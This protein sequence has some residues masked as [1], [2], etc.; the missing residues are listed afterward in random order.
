MRRRT[1]G[2]LAVIIIVAITVPSVLFVLNGMLNP[3]P[4]EPLNL[5][6]APAIIRE[7]KSDLKEALSD[8]TFS[9]DDMMN[10]SIFSDYV[11]A[12]HPE[13]QEIA[14]GWEITAVLEV[15]DTGYLWFI[16][17]NDT[18]DLEARLDPPEN[19][20]VTMS[21]SMDT[22]TEIFSCRTTAVSEFQR[23]MVGFDGPLQ[24]ALRIDRLNTIYSTTIMDT[25][26]YHSSD[27]LEIKLTQA[28][29]EASTPGLTLFPCVEVIITDESSP[30][31]S[32]G[33][34]KVMILDDEGQLVAQLDDSLHS[35]HKFFNSTAV[36]MGG[37]DGFME[38][39]DFKSDTRVTL[40]VPAGHHELDY[41]PITDT[42]MVLET[43]TAGEM[44]DGLEV[45]YDT[46]SEYSWEGDLLW[47]W[48][49][50]VHYPFNSTIH[51]TLG[52]N[53]TFRGYADW[54]HAN[55]FVWDKVE[56]TIWLNVRNQDTL[57]KIDKDTGEIVWKAG[58]HGNFTVLDI[59]GT[60][61]DTITNYPHS[62]EWIGGNRYIL[63][64]NGLFNPD[65]PSSMSQDGTGISGFVEFEID[66]ENQILREVW[67]WHALNE[68]YYFSESGGDADR[69]PDGNTLGIY[70]NMALVQAR[71]VPVILAEVSRAGEIV[72]E[73]QL[74]G[75]EGT[76]YWAHRVERFYEAPLIEVHDSIYDGTSQTL[77]VNM[78]TWN[79]VKQ[80]YSSAGSL[81]VLVNGDV[82][83]HE[84]FEFLPQWLETNLEISLNSLPTIVNTI[85][86][87]IEN[88]DGITNSVY[89]VGSGPQSVAPV[90]FV[91]VGLM[92]AI[93]VV[94]VVLVK[95]GRITKIRGGT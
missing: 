71:E 86:I 42:F 44:W 91:L 67:S 46:I 56:N 49:A 18:I 19:P 33:E 77:F 92:V 38:I 25:K 62:L 35:V 57:L 8:R 94:L 41:N 48:D 55:S 4:P 23:G 52:H 37:S 66:E 88:S 5:D 6:D 39:W 72:W 20:D 16:V 28:D 7:L 70:G 59:N 95:T 60:E 74:I 3:P 79:C 54:M 73:V 93:P 76:Y 53:Y 30:S 11:S 9:W 10:F 45:I 1:K 29:T 89:V 34:G 32:V 26:L 65:V 58:R 17:T 68:T 75:G 14:L 50:S 84:D 85:E 47:Q 90:F 31:G 78:S 27:V 13:A 81:A 87:V 61:V 69:L 43:T 83:Y 12:N 15:I 51:T 40:Q 63:F 80:M 82:F 22:L 24:D 36:L 2:L 64:D 21:V